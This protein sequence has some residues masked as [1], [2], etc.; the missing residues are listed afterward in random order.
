M[1]D[2]VFFVA[3]SPG[4]LIR[5]ISVPQQM[6]SDL[7]EISRIPPPVIEQIGAAVEGATGFLGDTRLEELVKEAIPD[8]ETTADAVL[9]ALRN[10]RSSSLEEILNA[11][12][13]WRRADARDLERFPD[14]AFASVRRALP[15]LV[16]PSAALD[17][18]REAARLRALT[19]HQG[20][21]VEIVCDARPV[22]DREQTTIEGFV[23][24]LTLK[25]VYETQSD[26]TRCIEIALS[27]ELVKELLDEAEKARKKLE[28]LGEFIRR[29]IPEGLAEPTSQ[30]PDENE[31]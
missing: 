10:L 9:N 14:E 2:R 17:R 16:R 6:I 25:L 13:E 24:Q 15:K 28:A 5:G 3:G 20:K 23:T 1:A 22:F 7:L 18:Q 4:G 19:G 31:S 26:D 8:N 21:R 29:W 30:I 27:P 12:E 11:L